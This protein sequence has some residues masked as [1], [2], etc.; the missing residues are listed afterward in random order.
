MI[1]R[2]TLPEWAVR[3]AGAP[4]EVWTEVISPPESSNLFYDVT[5][6]NKTATRL[7]EVRQNPPNQDL[8]RRIY[9]NIY[10]RSR[11]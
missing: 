2:A 6:V 3:E 5:W 11:T 9:A 4:T 7:P 1:L 10:Q 8:G